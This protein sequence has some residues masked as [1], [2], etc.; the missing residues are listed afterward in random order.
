MGQ[1]Q[2]I[3]KMTR[4]QEIEAEKLEVIRRRQ[5]RMAPFYRLMRK[6]VITLTLT[7]FLIYLGYIINNHLKG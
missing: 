7:I 4:L 3:K 6:F 2:R 1:K 5:D